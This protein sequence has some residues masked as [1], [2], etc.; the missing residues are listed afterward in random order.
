MRRGPILVTMVCLAGC[1][2]PE[3]PGLDWEIRFQP[4]VLRATAVVVNAQVRR[5]GCDAADVV[6]STEIRRGTAMRM[7]VASLAPG[8]Y[9]FFAEARDEDCALI[10]SGC[11]SLVLPANEPTVIT[12]LEA[13]SG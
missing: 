2:A 6:Y 3:R 13:A 9:G 7:V 4:E 12:T 5:V 10:A 11:S 8:A 1:S